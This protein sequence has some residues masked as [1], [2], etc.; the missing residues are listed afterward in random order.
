MSVAQD[1][2]LTKVQ[3]IAI[4]D[5]DESVRV[6]V[7][8][9]VRSLGYTACSFASADAFLRSAQLHSVSCVIADV[10]M[11]TMSGIELQAHLR[12]EGYKVPFIFITAAQE[13]CVRRQAFDD[14][15]ICFLN[16]PIDEETLI[17]CLDRAVEER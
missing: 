4:I 2:C 5:D 12:S 8:F 13:E 6:S 7:D 1:E 17:V 15:A 3:T 9:L 14:G 11:P 10:R 16:K